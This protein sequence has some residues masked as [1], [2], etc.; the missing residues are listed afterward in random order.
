MKAQDLAAFGQQGSQPTQSSSSGYFGGACGAPSGQSPPIPRPRPFTG[1]RPSP[2]G[3]PVLSQMPTPLVS[4][5]A[6]L[7]LA[8]AL[9]LFLALALPLVLAE[10]GL[11]CDRRGHEIN[12][13]AEFFIHLPR[14]GFHC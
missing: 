5:M 1:P 6:A 8:P 7:A 12:G 9:P 3:L 10:G 2:N 14:H 11:G 4:P 13:A